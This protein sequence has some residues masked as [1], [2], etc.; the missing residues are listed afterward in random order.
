TATDVVVP[1]A[2]IDRHFAT[3]QVVTQFY[4]LAQT[5]FENV[6]SGIKAQQIGRHNLARQKERAAD[7]GSPFLLPF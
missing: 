1:H 5:P 3:S 4:L 2:I 6:T 7:Y